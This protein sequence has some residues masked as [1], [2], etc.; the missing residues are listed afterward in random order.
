MTT[1][2]RAVC[3]AALP[4][5]LISTP[6]AAPS[7]GAAARV[8]EVTAER[9]EFW[10]SEI[11]VAQGEQLELR[12]RSDDTM[13]GFRI[14]GAGTNVLIPKRGKGAAVVR[15]TGSTPG[16]YT[17][18]CSRMCGAGHNFMRGVLVVRPAGGETR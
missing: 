3:A 13:H 14:V 15:F 4:I 18:E 2:A 16:R 11:V 12:I 6:G 17:F 10:P 8:I 5:L 7:Q 9:F 1:T